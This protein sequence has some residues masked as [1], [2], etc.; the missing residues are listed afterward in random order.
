LEGGLLSRAMPV[1]E[2]LPIPEPSALESVLQTARSKG[3]DCVLM[4]MRGVYKM[5]GTT[6]SSHTRAVWPDVE[7]ALLA[8]TAN[9]VVALAEL[10]EE[11][12]SGNSAHPYRKAP[13]NMT[14]SPTIILMGGDGKPKSRLV[15]AEISQ[16]SLMGMLQPFEKTGMPTVGEAV[17]QAEVDRLRAEVDKLKAEAANPALFL[18]RQFDNSPTAYF[19]NAPYPGGNTS[20]FDFTAQLPAKDA[21]T[22][23][24]EISLDKFKGKAIIVCNVA[25][26]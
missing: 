3:A 16:T 22:P 2:R 7:R 19:P 21:N 8:T 10:K 24:A 11:D 1:V 14:G 5:D 25:S 12:W 18:A 15:E 13:L 4:M 9:V 20:I 26:F 6:W 23:G 17:L